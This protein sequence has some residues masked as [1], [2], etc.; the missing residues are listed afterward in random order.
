MDR[1]MYPIQS[2][3]DSLFY[4][5]LQQASSQSLTAIIDATNLSL[6]ISFPPSSVPFFVLG[7]F[8]YLIQQTISNVIYSAALFVYEL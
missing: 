4:G 5:H 7:A 6:D 2:H 8:T 1:F 3:S